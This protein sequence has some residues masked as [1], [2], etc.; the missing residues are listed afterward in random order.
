MPTIKRKLIEVSPSNILE[1]IF[2][3][4][5]YLPNLINN[6]IINIIIYVIITVLLTIIAIIYSTII[7]LNL[8][9]TFDKLFKDTEF[10]NKLDLLSNLCYNNNYQNNQ[11]T[12]LRSSLDILNNKDNY[13]F[14]KGIP[15]KYKNKLDNK[16]K[17]LYIRDFYWKFSYKSYITGNI[18][19]GIPSYDAIKNAFDIHNVRGINLDIYSSSKIVGD[20]NAI[21][22]VRSDKLHENSSPLDLYKTFELINIHGWDNKTEYKIKNLPIV[23]YLTINFSNDEIIYNKIHYALIQN[24]SKRL[25]NKKY[26]FNGRNGLNSINN[27][28]MKDAIGK[29]IIITNQY[30]TNSKL[31]E[32]I[33]GTITNKISSISLD[34]YTNDM[35]TYDGISI[36][37]PKSDLINNNKDNLFMTYSNNIENKDTKLNSK[38]DLSNPNIIDCINSGIQFPMMSLYLPNKNLYDWLAYFDDDAII[39]K[40]E[41]LR[42]TELKNDNL[43]D[44]L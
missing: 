30:P 41:D 8:S 36:K 37:Y 2:N 33:N 22:I 42:N 13:E 10:I 27:I 6:S 5:L 32:L 21:P 1:S 14:S 9:N 7:I 3:K 44:L 40:N 38:I 29:I 16:F 26:S 18:D 39:L 34:K 28:L 35:H 23:L 15:I 11:I 20:I 43:K 19:N 25:M 24:F 17:D 31:D 4:L 12:S